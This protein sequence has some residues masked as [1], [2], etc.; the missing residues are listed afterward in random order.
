M[1]ASTSDARVRI[2]EVTTPADPVVP[3]AYALL[4]RAFP[5]SERV[6]LREW[7]ATLREKARRVWSDYNWHLLVAQRGRSVVGLVTGTYLGNV[8]VGVIGY[9][10]IMAG[11]RGVG[12]GTLLRSRLRRAFE[13]DARQL[14]GRPLGG[15][16]GEVSAGN[17]WLATLARRPDVLVLDLAYYQPRLRALDRPS[18]FLLYYESIGRPRRHLPAAELRRILYGIW[19]RA[20]RITRPL[21]RAAFRRMLRALDRRRRIGPHPDFPRS[22]AS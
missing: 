17:P 12:L 18:P 8:N 15:I 7:R 14:V 5:P 21:E 6:P 22:R 11:A 20:Y 13:R 16:V 10:A 9:L 4:R 1:P 19:R 3:A 2:R